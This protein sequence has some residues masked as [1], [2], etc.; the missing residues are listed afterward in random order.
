MNSVQP[1]IIHRGGARSSKS[2]SILQYLIWR[3]TNEDN[4]KILITRKTMPALKL[5]A[6]KDYIDLLKEYGYYQYCDHSLTNNYVTYKP[7]NAFVAFLSL[8]NPERIK[9][10]EWN[11][12]FIEEA[13]EFTYN[14][15]MTLKTR[16]SAHTTIGNKLILAFNPTDAFSYIKTEVIDKDDDY[17]EFVSNYK[18]NPFLSKEYV[19]IL[20]STKNEH[21]KRVFVDGEW[22]I[23]EGV[24]F[25]NWKEVNVLPVAEKTVY[26][27]DFGFTDET[28]CIEA[29][30]SKDGI[31]VKQLLY[32]SGMTNSELI[33]W[34]K[35]NLTPG[36]TIVA[37]SSEPQRIVEMQEAN[38]F[39][40]SA[41][42]GPDSV[43]KSIDT[44]QSYP[45]L[46]DSGSVDIIKEL[47]S[48]QWI[49][50]RSTGM[51]KDKPQDGFDHLIDAM[52]YAIHTQWG[53]PSKVPKMRNIN[54]TG[55]INTRKVKVRGI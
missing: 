27:I 29:G 15:Y 38:L 24:I 21:Y 9:S 3:M 11:V 10:S 49:K 50:D 26:G 43:R 4:C 25:T 2:Y 28:A 51:L 5:T 20:L 6:Y 16:L 36:R 32:R 30:I 33:K 46:I 19:D 14:D 31:S 40:K 13:T 1:V 7:N 45:L 18:D 52:R 8:D 12:V 55:H 41:E 22:G 39:V 53:V 37:D 23:L 48:Y 42:K 54:M 47:R 35:A 34:C 17:D 44:V